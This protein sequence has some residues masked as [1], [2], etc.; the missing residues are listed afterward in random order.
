[1]VCE[2]AHTLFL[3]GN[4][5]DKNHGLNTSYDAFIRWLRRNK[6]NEELLKRLALI[7]NT[8]QASLESKEQNWSD[9]ESGFG[10]IN[11]KNIQFLFN[12]IGGHACDEDI[13]LLKYRLATFIESAYGDKCNELYPKAHFPKN[14]FFINFNYT[15]VLE[16]IYGIKKEDIIHIHGLSERVHAMG[17][18]GV[19]EEPLVFGCSEK[20][21]RPSKNPE[22]NK[23][24][25]SN[26]VKDTRRIFESIRPKIETLNVEKIIVI[27]LSYSEPDAPYFE[28]LHSLFPKAAWD[29]Y[30]YE[31]DHSTFSHALTIKRSVFKKA[32]F[33]I[34]TYSDIAKVNMID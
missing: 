26:L 24:F 13:A 25:R 9:F 28:Y 21:F 19:P 33:N 8:I 6:D 1:M 12:W 18:F 30:V 17:L 16:T 3:L 10:D 23:F 15:S 31:R 34:K 4:G 27:G 20:A 14:A 29:A 32:I 11:E 2:Q 5:F 22:I 7:N